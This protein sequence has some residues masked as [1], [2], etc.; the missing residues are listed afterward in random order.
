MNA[1][2]AENEQKGIRDVIRTIDRLPKEAQQRIR[3]V[4]LHCS[5]PGKWQAQNHPPELPGMTWQEKARIR[6][7]NRRRIDEHRPFSDPACRKVVAMVRP[8]FLAHEFV[9]NTP[10]SM[11]AALRQQRALIGN[12]ASAAAPSGDLKKTWVICY[13]NT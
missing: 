12:G 2:Q 3:A 8:E 1:L 11:Q 6:A 9:A 4:H 7:E 10:E 5:T 13:F